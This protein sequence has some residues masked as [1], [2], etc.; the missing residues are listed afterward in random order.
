MKN[1]KNKLVKEYNSLSDTSDF[2]LY[3]TSNYKA[4]INNSVSEILT[5]FIEV[6]IEYMKFISEK[7]IMK[8][9]SYYHFIFERGIATLIHIFSL[10]FYYTKNLEIG[11]VYSSADLTNNF[12]PVPSLT[13]ISAF[14]SKES[15]Q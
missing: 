6:I 15:V 11:D 7:M 2:V 8:N 10:I 9:N 14:F 13:P 3:N 4:V 12:S 1:S 5:K